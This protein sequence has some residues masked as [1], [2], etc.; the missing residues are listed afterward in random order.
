MSLVPSKS[1]STAPIF[2]PRVEDEITS[3]QKDMNTLMSSFFNRGELSVPQYFETGVYPSIDLR[4]VGDKFLLDA[5][6]PGMNE[7]DI[8][9]DLHGNTLTIKGEKKSEKETKESD[10]I[11]VERSRGSFRRDIYLGQEVDQASVKAELKD[12]VLHIELVKKQPNKSNHKK[13]SIRH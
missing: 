4:E 3:F 2:S 7:A 13:I 11:C 10:Y 8:D 6:V 1:T 12:G 9:I 5:D